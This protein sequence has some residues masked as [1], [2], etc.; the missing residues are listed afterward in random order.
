MSPARRLAP[1]TAAVLLASLLGWW[2]AVPGSWT[3]TDG[4]TWAL[5]G[6]FVLVVLAEA[7]QLR[8]EIR[9]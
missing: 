7:A 1:V 3:G 5:P 4:W 6:L 9:R 2:A 8:V